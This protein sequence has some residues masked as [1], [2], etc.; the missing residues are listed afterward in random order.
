MA[1]K[2]F[3][4]ING[5]KYSFSSESELD[6]FIRNN[7]DTL[8]Y[9]NKYGDVVFDETN[10]IQSNIYNKLLTIN[11]NNNTN[12][13]NELTQENEVVT[14]KKLG[15]TTAITTWTTK[16]GLV[17]P[18]FRLEEY[19]KNE[20][21]LLLKQGLSKEEAINKIDGDIKNWE[22][23]AKIGD[24]VHKVAELYFKDQDLNSICQ[25]V[26]LPYDTIESLYYNFETLKNTIS[27]GKSYKFIPELT[28]ET[29]GDDSDPIIGRIDLIA[30]DENG[31]IEIYDFKISNKP[32][33]SWYSSKQITIDYQLACYR[34]LLANNGINIKS[35]S[36]NIIPIIISG[37]DYDSE[38]FSSYKLE[39]P[40]DRTIDSKTS[41]KLSYPNGYITKIVQEHIKPNFK[42]IVYDS[43]K[44]KNVY[45]YSEVAFGKMFKETPEDFVNRVAKYD[46]YTKKWYFIDFTSNTENDESRIEADTKEEL[47]NKANDYLLKLEEDDS[48]YTNLWKYFNTL[49]HTKRALETDNRFKWLPQK[50]NS[51]LTR[52]FCNYIDNP[53]YEILD[54]PDL[55]KLGIYLFRDIANNIV[56][57]VSI[58][59]YDL[60]DKIKWDNKSDNI[61]GNLGSKSK[62]KNIKN[63]MSNNIGNAQLLK[64][65]LLINE[66][67]DYFSNFK[68]GNIEVLSYKRGQ[69][70]PVDIDKL[71]H[72]FDVLCKELQIENHFKTNITIADRIESLKLKLLTLLGSTRTELYKGS[73]DLIY[74]FYNNY[75]L[76]N[77][78]AKYK[79]EQL[80]KIQEIIKE[81][82]GSR[83]IIKADNNYDSDP[84][85][86]S[87]LYATV[88]RLILHYKK[89]YFDSDHDINQLGFNLT[90]ISKTLT[91]NGYFV[92]NPEMIALIKDIVDMTEIQFQKMREQFMR[93]KEVSL[94]R[95]LELYKSKGYTQTERWTF[96][97]STKA[98]SNMFKRD[99]TGKI[100]REFRVKNPYDPNE[101]L[102]E[103]ERKWLKIFLWNINRVKQGIDYN[104]TEEE[105]I[106]DSRVKELI[107]SGHYFDV[108][109]LRGSL[110]SQMRSKNF[111]SFLK[112]K[113]N[114]LVDIRRVTKAQEETI[115]SDPL[116]GKNDYLTMYNF[117][118]VSPTT[119]ENYL[120]EKDIDYWETNLELIEDVFVHAYIRKS[121]FDTILPFINDIRHTI[122]LRSY[123]TNID[124]TNLTRQIDIYL[125]SVI[126]GESSIEKSNQAFFK[127]MKSTLSGARGFMLAFNM[128]SFFREPVQGF[129]LTM[130]RSMSRLFGD[131]GFTPKEALEAWK[132][133]MC[134]TGVTTD[135]WTLVESL[136]HFYGM[137]RM[138]ANSLAYEL[139]SDRKGYKGIIRKGP[140]WATTAPDF[141]NRMTF[142]VAQMIHDGCLKAHTIKD[143]ELIYDWTKD[144]RYSV[145]ASGDKTD[146]RYN[147]QKSDYIA[148]LI[149]FNLEHEN[150]VDWEEL[151]FNESNPVALPSAYTV[152]EKRNIKSSADSLFGYMDHEN[153]FAARHKFVGKLIFQFKSYFSS[154]RERF[155]LEGTDKSPKG[156][157][158]QKTDENGNLLYLKLVV[159]EN[160][161]EYLEETT[162]VTD[163]IAQEWTG[164]FIEGMVNSTIY[165][166]KYLYN[167]YLKHNKDYELEY[168]D[169]RKR[170]AKELLA[171][172]MWTALL[173][174][175]FSL[176]MKDKESKGEE[177]DPFV[178]NILRQSLINSTDE[179][180]FTTPIIS[181]TQT[182]IPLVFIERINQSYRNVVSGK[183]DILKE[184]PKNIY[185]IKQL[186][187]VK[188]F[189]TEEY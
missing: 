165:Y 188:N 131:N 152:A 153:A 85:G 58:C 122:H 50:V 7:Y 127:V 93:Y 116:S 147:K 186:N 141:M 157:W 89:M 156:E 90:D 55:A 171:D 155:F 133:V 82:A 172:S 105:A 117:L 168:K 164:R 64:T 17:I 70:Y 47:I 151:K 132:I 59:N 16:N 24:K 173:A 52:F 15:V 62:F 108:P 166:F 10:A 183:S 80:R 121:N 143:G 144:D 135:E 94:K 84:T 109:L 34:A 134:N 187:N 31:D 41:Q 170:N 75:S 102:T 22:H 42:E 130:S 86:L 44:I 23:L 146:P 81:V 28:L 189:I 179:L 40:I 184:I 160:G 83:L 95:V 139:N 8:L 21:N 67:H 148:H 123:D 125:K 65:M 163:I 2:Y 35:A 61:F 106:N 182:P 46:N 167:Y 3:L 145:F 138:D 49:K 107:Q 11:V 26:D 56:D 149:Q 69:T 76:D 177:Y 13:F 43:E 98:F 68:I 162:E 140:Y 48:L 39:L 137:T 104:L 136:N 159:D 79:I 19:K 110:F 12:K 120:L 36:L 63:L 60:N 142:L 88:S 25:I 14:P 129:Y 97:D 103:G 124:Y 30:I 51:Y 113:F 33:D 1:C 169:Y 150:D 180:L 6:D 32:Y 91:L 72:N 27:K 111:S 77:E 37:I 174:L 115:E 4:N 178:K 9:Y 99:N 20:L 181:L 96:R 126:F 161:N 18:E 29:K 87:L 78:T 5:N 92:E 118:N 66:L 185:F 176:L 54:C 101:D 45:K 175:L 57:V 158:K 114:E 112:D 154:T 119:R 53:G 74:D 71:T 38:T 128:N 100:A 73:S